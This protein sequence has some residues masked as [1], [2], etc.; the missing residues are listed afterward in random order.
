VPTKLGPITIRSIWGE[1]KG[2]WS[3]ERPPQ[4]PGDIRVFLGILRRFYLESR[5]R[6]VTTQDFIRTVNEMTQQDYTQFLHE[7]LYTKRR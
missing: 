7:R 1:A 2:K 5:F 6:P 3:I 4:I